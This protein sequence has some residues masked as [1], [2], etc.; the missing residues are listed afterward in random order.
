MIRYIGNGAGV[1]RCRWRPTPGPPGRWR[2]WSRRRWGRRPGWRRWRRRRPGR[3]GRRGTPR[4]RRGSGRR[5]RPGW[6]AGAGPS[7]RA[8]RGWRARGDAL[9]AAGAVAGH[10]QGGLL[11]GG[12]ALD[13]GQ[14]G[15]VGAD[16]QLQFDRD[17]AVQPPVGD[18]APVQGGPL[19]LG[20]L[21]AAEAV[22][23]AGRGPAGWRTVASTV[24]TRPSGRAASRAWTC[25]GWEPS[26]QAQ[27]SKKWTPCS[28][29]MPPLTRRS[30]NQWS[31]SRCS[32][33]AR[34][35]RRTAG[36]APAG[37]AGAG[38]PGRT[39]GCGAARSR[40]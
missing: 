12:E 37:P 29:A 4:G 18:L 23:V 14:A 26:S 25:S 28:T 3:P 6:R 10:G 31:G 22:G 32:S 39:A 7:G 9:A 21:G 40:P 19:G 20:P 24:S 34:F 5:G 27:A 16:V 38:R 33:P 35:S 15:A 2:G 17:P 1:S 13:G 30:Q 11:V 8:G 36:A